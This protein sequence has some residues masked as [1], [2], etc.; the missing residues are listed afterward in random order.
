MFGFGPYNLKKI[1]K[2]CRFVATYTQC[3]A[4]QIAI[5]SFSKVSIQVGPK[6]NEPIT[7]YIES[8]LLYW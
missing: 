8:M 2:N 1:S 4:M 5:T 3:F 7:P 6:F